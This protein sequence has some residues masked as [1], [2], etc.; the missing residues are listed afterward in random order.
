MAVA[1]RLSRS[2]SKGKP[3]Y[4]IVATDKRNKRDGR[5]IE[6]LGTY[7]PQLEDN[8]VVLNKERYDY[9]I[10][11]GAKPSETVQN[12]VKTLKNYAINAQIIKIVK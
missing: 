12:L 4:K 8:K 3:F 2:G 6:K 5:F 10:S 9:W 7:D 11:V 1:I